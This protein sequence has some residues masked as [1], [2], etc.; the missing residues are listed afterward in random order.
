M[1]G[2]G[3]GQER[4]GGRGD[5]QGLRIGVRGRES[6]G[7]GANVCVH[8]CGVVGWEQDSTFVKSCFL[9]CL[10]KERQCLTTIP[11]LQML[12]RII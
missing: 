3:R 12:F 9:D 1:G 8:A 7:R 2:E 10:Q 11:C 5:D 4:V 6:G